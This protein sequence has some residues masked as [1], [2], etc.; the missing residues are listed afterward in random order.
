M[1]YVPFINIRQNTLNDG[2]RETLRS[3]TRR[4]LFSDDIQTHTLNLTLTNSV[5]RQNETETTI[6]LLVVAMLD[7]KPSYFPKCVRYHVYST[8]FLFWFSFLIQADTY[9]TFIFDS[10]ISKVISLKA[11]G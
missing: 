10:F 7:F 4:P 1:C 8:D 9:F 6:K 2:K 3:G 5:T 11:E